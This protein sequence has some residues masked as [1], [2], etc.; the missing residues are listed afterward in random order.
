MSKEEMEKR[1]SEIGKSDNSQN[2]FDNM[3][4]PNLLDIENL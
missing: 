4:D 3:K 2:E 1:I